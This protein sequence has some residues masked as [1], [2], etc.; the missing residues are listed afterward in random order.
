MAEGILSGRPVV[1]SRV[2]PALSYVRDAVVEVPPDDIEGYG[3]ALLRLCDD[4]EFYEEK[5]RSCL[6]A[7]EQFY[8]ISQSWGA[9]LKSVLV[10]I[11]ESREL[12]QTLAD[13]EETKPLFPHL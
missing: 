6:R 12:D 13:K 7:Q 2:C 3:N 4:R 1:T 11:Q 9:A 10:K 5:R 8:D